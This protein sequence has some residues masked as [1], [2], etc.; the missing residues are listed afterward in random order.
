M[1]PIAL[2]PLALVL[3][4]LAQLVV[5]VDPAQVPCTD[6]RGCPDLA[7]DHPSL[8]VGTQRTENFGPNHCAVQEGAVAAGARQLIRV[9]FTF[10]NIGP[11]DLELGAPADHPGWFEWSSCHGHYHV[12]EHAA[13]RVWTINGFLAW[14]EYRKADPQ[15]TADEVL[16]AHPEL[17]DE[18][19]AG[20]KQGFCIVSQ[21]PYPPGLNGAALTVDPIPEHNQFLNGDPCTDN[22]GQDPGWA[23]TYAF[24]Q[25]GMWVDVTGMATGAYILEG[26]MNANHFIIETRYD[27]NRA[28]VPIE[29]V[30]AL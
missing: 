16:A 24:F 30:S 18:F 26:E 2:M 25:D 20:K 13:F 9:S 27:N 3:L 19:V 8:L 5:G 17:A 6:T 12:K 7:T 10:G 15:L 22:Q 14:D 11:G 4:P 29:V 23:D 28:A 1:R 21:E